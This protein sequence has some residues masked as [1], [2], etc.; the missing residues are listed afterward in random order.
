MVIVQQTSIA[1]AAAAAASAL[2]NEDIA[3]NVPPWCV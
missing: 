2:P 1:V 3:K